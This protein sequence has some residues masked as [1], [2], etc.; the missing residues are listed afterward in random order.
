MLEAPI[1]YYEVVEDTWTFAEYDNTNLVL[2][3]T[4]HNVRYIENF[5]VVYACFK[6]PEN[7]VLVEPSH[8]QIVQMLTDMGYDGSTNNMAN[9]LVPSL[10]VINK[11]NKMNSRIQNKRVLGDL[12]RLKKHDNVPSVLPPEGSVIGDVSGEGRGKNQR[13]PKDK[14]GKDAINVESQPHLLQIIVETATHSSPASH[15]DVD[16]ISNFQADSPSLE[17]MEKPRSETDVHNLLDDL[18]VLGFEHINTTE[19]Q[20]VHSSSSSG[21][22]DTI[23]FSVYA[24]LRREFDMLQGKYDRLIDRLK[25]VYPDSRNNEGKPR[26]QKTA[27]LETL[28]QYVNTKLEEMPSHRDRTSQYIIQTVADELQSIVKMLREEKSTKPRSD[29]V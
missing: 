14:G 18:L 2:S 4:F 5:G 13:N 17:I 11:T 22:D 1:I 10:N 15:M 21:S 7:K 24:E 20:R 26:E 19:T 27:R 29:G 8:V 6:I 16:L 25:N 23:A 12:S 28:V 3:F 9:H